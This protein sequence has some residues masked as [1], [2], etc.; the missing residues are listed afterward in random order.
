MYI[1][2]LGGMRHSFGIHGAV[3]QQQ[4]AE[5]LQQTERHSTSAPQKNYPL[6]AQSVRRDAK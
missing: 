4:P 3:V 2:T 1:R 5:R 6:Y